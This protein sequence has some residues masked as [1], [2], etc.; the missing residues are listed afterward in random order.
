MNTKVNNERLGKVFKQPPAQ[1][2]RDP[3]T[4]RTKSPKRIYKQCN[5][6]GSTKSLNIPYNIESM[7]IETDNVIANLNLIDKKYI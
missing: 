1:R 2:N 3:S 5:A 7:D 6:Q 4:S